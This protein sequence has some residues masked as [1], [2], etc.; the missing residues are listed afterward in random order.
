MKTKANLH[1][2]AS[3]GNIK[4]RTSTKKSSRK[5]NSSR[6]F[7]KTLLTLLCL[8]ILGG[9]FNFVHSKNSGPSVVYAEQHLSDLEYKVVEIESGDSLWSIAKENMTPGFHDINEYIDEIIECNQL[10]SDQI[11]EGKYLLIPYYEVIAD[12]TIIASQ[13]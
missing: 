6:F 7:T 2:T 8:I 4:R 1:R 5:V 11:T 12:N 3:A 9:I 13:N 10:N